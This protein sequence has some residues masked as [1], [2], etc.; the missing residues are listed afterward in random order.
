[1][2]LPAL[3]NIPYS[4][5]PADQDLC[6]LFTSEAGKRVLAS[7]RERGIPVAFLCAEIDHAIAR[8]RAHCRTG[9]QTP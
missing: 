5:D 6:T 1:M 7:W 4:G 8:V 2:N 3:R 9:G